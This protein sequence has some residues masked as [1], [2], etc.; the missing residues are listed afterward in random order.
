[1]SAVKHNI[2]STKLLLK[3]CVI[4]TKDKESAFP[5]NFVTGR[6]T[7]VSMSVNSALESTKLGHDQSVPECI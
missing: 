1:M 7:H 6:E 2:L 5:V 4:D 3:H